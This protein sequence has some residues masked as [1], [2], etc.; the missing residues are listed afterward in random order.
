MIKSHK[1]PV[2]AVVRVE[3]AVA[4]VRAVALQPVVEQVG[5]EP[6][7]AREQVVRAREREVLRQVV[8]LVQ[9]PARQPAATHR[10]VLA[11]AAAEPQPAQVAARRAALVPAAT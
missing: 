4:Q 7:P 6:E 8:L 11:L 1:R 5:P 2:A 10:P 3:Q 9:V